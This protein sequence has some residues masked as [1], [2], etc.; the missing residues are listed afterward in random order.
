MHHHR[1]RAIPLLLLVLVLCAALPH[2]CAEGDAGADSTYSSGDTY[3]IQSDFNLNGETL[4]IHGDA[5]MDAN[6]SLKGG[7]LKILGN[8]YQYGGTMSID[9]GTLCVA[10]GYYIV[11]KDSNFKKGT[12]TACSGILKMV[13]EADEVQIGGSF[14]TKSNVDHEGYLTAGVLYVGGDFTQLNGGSSYNFNASAGHKTVLNGSAEQVISFESKYSGFGA[15]EATAG[16]AVF[17]GNVNWLTQSGEVH[18]GSRNAHLTSRTI[19]LNGKQLTIDGE[20]WMSGSNVDLNGGQMTV[21]GTLYQAAGTLNV[22]TGSA[23]IGNYYIVGEDSVFEEGKESYTSSSG[24][25]KMVNAADK[26]QI[27]GSFLTKSNNSHT[28]YLT[29]GVLYVGGDFTQLNGGSSYN[30]NAYAGHKTV[31]NGSA[32]QVISFESEYSGFGALEAPAGKAVFEGNVSWLTQSGDVYAGSRNAHLPYR[33]IDLNGK[34]LAITGD[35]WMSGS[36]VDLNGGQLTVNGTLYQATGTL[37]V[38]GGSAVIGNYYIVGETSSIEEGKYTNSGGI[39]QMV[40]EA[41]EVRVVGNFLTKSDFGHYNYLKAGV[42]YVGGDFTQLNGAVGSANGTC[43]FEAQAG[44]KTVLNGR[45]RQTV[46]FNSNSSHFG[47]LQLTKPRSNYTFTL[48]PCWTTL[49]EA[50]IPALTLPAALTQIEDEAFMNNTELIAVS[51]SGQTLTRIG[52]GAFKGCGNLYEITIP[53]SVTWIAPDA[54][55]GCTYL[56]ILSEA[57]SYAQQY[58]EAHGIDWLED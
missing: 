6:V 18:V 27:G 55:E 19:N 24:I 25:L 14:L 51:I 1:F 30:F 13:N 45:G 15:L 9:G 46:S 41:D 21:N 40:N 37:N 29:A 26:V 42:L 16:K 53:G 34:K 49:V 22:N 39:L 50:D 20:I 7:T 58:A 57:G 56:T 54:F 23:V 36:N 10:K 35:I 32:E 12:Y 43:N 33:D 48:N 2:A 5:I 31:L 8:L 3:W 11:G 47:I 17:E 28:N 4:T 38:N 52:S 44:H